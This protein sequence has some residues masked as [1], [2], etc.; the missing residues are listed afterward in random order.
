[1]LEGTASHTSPTLLRGAQSG[2]ADAWTELVTV[3]GRRVYRWCRRAGLQP[4]DAANVTQEVFRSVARKLGGFRHDRDGDTFR[5]WLRRITQNKLRDFQRALVRRIDRAPGGTDA[6]EMLLDVA[7]DENGY[8]SELSF[9]FRLPPRLESAMAQ[10][11]A[12]FSDRDWHLFWRVVVDGQSAAEAGE[13][14]G[15]SGNAVRLIKMRMLRR[16]REL[17]AERES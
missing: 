10:V 11:R 15:V 16:F 7:A 8:D 2:D 9:E 13:E 12:E 17:L 3:Y 4:A 14:F 5:G 1:M 6:H